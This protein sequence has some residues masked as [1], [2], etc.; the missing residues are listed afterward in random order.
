[1]QTTGEAQYKKFFA[2]ILETRL[3][4]Q[5]DRTTQEIQSGFRQDHIFSIR[6]ISKKAI[7]TGKQILLCLID[8]EKV[9][10][11]V[12]K[13]RLGSAKEQ[14]HYRGSNKKHK[15]LYTNTRRR[16]RKRNKQ[17]EHENKQ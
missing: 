4:N 16:V 13:I 12:K 1:M 5:I 11:R 14:K 3:R 10:D 2:Q 6:Q 15:S 9:F 7:K 17:S 8:M